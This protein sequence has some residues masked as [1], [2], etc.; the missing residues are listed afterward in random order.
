MTNIL[1]K[2]AQYIGTLSTDN[3]RFFIYWFQWILRF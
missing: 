2:D 3:N 1:H